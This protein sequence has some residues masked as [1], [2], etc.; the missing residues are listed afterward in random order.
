MPSLVEYH[1]NICPESLLAED[2]WQ[3]I[4][5]EYGDMRSTL[6]NNCHDWVSV[7]MESCPHCG[8]TCFKTFSLPGNT[9]PTRPEFTD[10]RNYMGDISVK[11]FGS[12]G[13]FD[14]PE[15]KKPAPPSF[16]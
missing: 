13:S 15:S 4:C 1:I 12:V 6:C 14:E 9:E 16:S 8:S 2:I 5:F 7:N 10:E 3:G 11:E